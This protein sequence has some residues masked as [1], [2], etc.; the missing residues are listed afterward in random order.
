M[1]DNEKDWKPRKTLKNTKN[2]KTL[3]NTGKH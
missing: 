3:I 2:W 1:K